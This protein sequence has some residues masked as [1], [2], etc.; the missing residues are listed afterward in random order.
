MLAASEDSVDVGENERC[1]T[2]F[3]FHLKE[4][5]PEP[6]CCRMID[7]VWVLS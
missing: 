3:F 1:L 4:V 7:D 2:I 6:A 5:A